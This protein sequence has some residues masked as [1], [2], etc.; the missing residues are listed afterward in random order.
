MAKGRHGGRPAGARQH[1]GGAQHSGGRKGKRGAPAARD[2]L[3][4]AA[5][6]SAGAPVS[7]SVFGGAV[8]LPSPRPV[9]RPRD[10]PRGGPRAEEARLPRRRIAL[11]DFSYVSRDLRWIAAASLASLAL[12]LILWVVLRVV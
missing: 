5:P 6:G 7:S 12:V 3:P 8:S 2:E 10:L 9:R 4:T 11:R 1:R